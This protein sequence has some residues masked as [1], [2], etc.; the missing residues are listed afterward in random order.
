MKSIKKIIKSCINR[1]LCIGAGKKLQRI[2]FNFENIMIP[3]ENKM[4]N[5]FYRPQRR[6]PGFLLNSKIVNNDFNVVSPGIQSFKENT[7]SL[8]KNRIYHKEYIHSSN[9]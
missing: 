7:V 2:N 3:E 6:D 4:K 1:S 8:M 5:E 9:N